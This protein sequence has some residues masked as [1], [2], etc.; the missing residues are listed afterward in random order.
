MLLGGGRSARPV[1]IIAQH[2]DPGG[3]APRRHRCQSQKAVALADVVYRDIDQDL[4]R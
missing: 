2:A 1:L 3:V 4:G